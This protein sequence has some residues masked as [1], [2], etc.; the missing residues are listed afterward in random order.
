MILLKRFVFLLIIILCLAGCKKRTGV[1]GIQ[2]SS[3]VKNGNQVTPQ[4]EADDLIKEIR[5]GNPFRPDHATGASSAVGYNTELRGIIWDPEAPYALIGE[6]VVREG[7]IFDNKKVIKI[8]KNSVV[9]DNNGQRE[10]L[11]LEGSF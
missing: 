4:Q 1:Q 6:F 10:T 8:N 7:D 9:L 3:F 2:E 5:M 11:K